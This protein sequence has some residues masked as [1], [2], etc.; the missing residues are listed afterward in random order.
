MGESISLLIL[1]D[2]RLLR[3]GIAAM[4][5]QQPDLEVVG[6]AANSAMALTLL[7]ELK[8]Q[9]VLLDS[10]L[11]DLNNL[12]SLQS[13]WDGGRPARVIVMDLLPVPQEVVAFIRAGV[14]GFIAKDATLM[15]L[16]STIRSV[17]AGRSVLP[18]VYAETIFSHIAGQAVI[19]GPAKGLDGTRMTRRERE[20]LELIGQGLS[21]KEIAYRLHISTQTVKS[22]VHNILEK[23]AL[24]T[25]LQIAAYI[26]R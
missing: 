1:E 16:V 15:E 13:V 22:H 5:E 7:Q 2:N 14:C 10:G 18:S 17:A 23:L 11:A 19:R 25:R 9:I 20:V 6:T 3:E 24:H 12:A 26:H 21:N 4:L 8:P